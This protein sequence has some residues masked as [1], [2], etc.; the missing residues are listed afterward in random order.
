MVELRKED[1][2]TFKIFIYMPTEMYEEI[3]ERVSHRIWKQH[4]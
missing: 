3:L 2:R 1:H 4:T